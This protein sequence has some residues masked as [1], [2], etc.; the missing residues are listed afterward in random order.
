[1]T[2]APT[3]PD[4]GV[5]VGAVGATR[6]ERTADVLRRLEG[7]LG[8]GAGALRLEHVCP[9]CG[10]RD[11]GAPLL[12][13]RQ[14]AAGAD[15]G[16]RPGL[17]AKAARRT[18][19]G[20]GAPV[21]RPVLPAV[22]LSHAE[23]PRPVTVLAWC[24]PRD[25]WSV[26]VDVED[27]DGDRVRKAL[28]S[29][30]DGTAAADTVAFTAAQRAGFSRLP[31][32]QAYAARVQAWCRAEALVKARGTGFTADPHTVQPEPG[33]Q[34]RVLTAALAPGLPDTVCGVLV[35]RAPTGRD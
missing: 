21:P 17:R 28:S 25:G 11:H 18:L 26:G 2:T 23:G 10:G 12:A 3:A 34:V 30:A 7:L 27:R 33:E 20:R 6:A 31:A 8:L 9:G 16:L 19:R 15:D 29:G 4:H 32:A 35:L 22:S 24:A 1:M 13:W 14:P 5:L